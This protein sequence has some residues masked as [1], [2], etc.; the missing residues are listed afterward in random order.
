MRTTIATESYTF[1]EI[2]AEL[3]NPGIKM[4]ESPLGPAPIERERRK[5]G[6]VVVRHGIMVATGP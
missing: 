5:H 3:D 2:A 1:R 6:D 4:T